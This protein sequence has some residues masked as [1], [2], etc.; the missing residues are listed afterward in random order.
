MRLTAAWLP[1][2]WCAEVFNG[3][4]LRESGSRLKLFALCYFS[5]IVYRLIMCVWSTFHLVLLILLRGIYRAAF[6]DLNGFGTTCHCWPTFLSVVSQLIY[7][8][9]RHRVTMKVVHWWAEVT[10]WR[11][12]L[13]KND[14]N[15]QYCRLW[16]SLLSIA[17]NQICC[18]LCC[19]V[20]HLWC[21]Q[22]SPDFFLFF[23]GGCKQ[24]AKQGW[25]ILV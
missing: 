16:V 25:V 12:K 2:R 7:C 15:T 9:G 11:Q 18:Y 22:K 13:D 19:L 4:R 14:L 24:R 1:F 23:C 5:R 17:N 3:R 10:K 6:W 21:H 8:F 20:F